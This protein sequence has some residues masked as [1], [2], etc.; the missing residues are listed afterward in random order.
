MQIFELVLI[1]KNLKNI[2][3]TL[4]FIK[5]EEIIFSKSKNVFQFLWAIKF[6]KKK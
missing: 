6:F 5:K 1:I 2:S 3:G 4:T